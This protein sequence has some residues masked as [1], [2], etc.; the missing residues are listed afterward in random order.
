MEANIHP[1]GLPC[2][3]FRRFIPPD[4]QEYFI[5]AMLEV[6]KDLYHAK[7]RRAA[8]LWFWMQ[9]FKSMPGFLKH[10]F[11]RSNMMC[12]NY[13]KIAFRNLSKNKA[14]SCINILGLA[15]GMS[16]FLLIFLYVTF[17]LSYENFHKNR[18]RIYRLRNDRIYIQQKVFCWL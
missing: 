13:F 14:F 15:I 8:R 1:P 3:L 9:F 17:E 12:K 10:S 4:E 5:S 2:W 18:D 6:Y 7:G 16:A 11:I